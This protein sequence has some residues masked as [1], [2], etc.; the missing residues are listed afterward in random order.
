LTPY[1]IFES[2]KVGLKNDDALNDLRRLYPFAR[3][4]AILLMLKAYRYRLYPDKN[5]T[6]LIN[7]HIGSCRFIYNL[8]LEVKNYAYTT[9]RKTVSCF[10]LINQ[11]KD[12]KEV[13]PWLYEVDSQALQQSIINLDNAFTLFFKGHSSF[14]KFRN[15]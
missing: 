9:Q 3:K 4:L 7:K 6:V 5:Q 13:C 11:L 8:A 15:K 12:L 10:E 1:V 2:A 14:P